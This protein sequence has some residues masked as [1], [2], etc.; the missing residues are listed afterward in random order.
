MDAAIRVL[1][2]AVTIFSP[3]SKCQKITSW[4]CSMIK[5]SEAFS[6]STGSIIGGCFGGFAGDF[7]ISV[8]RRNWGAPRGKFAWVEHARAR[9]CS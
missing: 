4:Y 8:S 3:N 1:P 7:G 6:S 9:A 5:C 2:G